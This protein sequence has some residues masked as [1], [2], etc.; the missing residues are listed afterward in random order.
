[1]LNERIEADKVR[2]LGGLSFSRDGNYL[3]FVKSEKFGFLQTLYRMSVLGGVSTQ[4]ISDVY[5]YALSPDG[6]QLAFVRNSQSAD[7]S[8]L[9]IANA[10]GT[11]AYR[12]ATRKFTDPFVSLG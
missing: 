9:M 12:L 3:Y 8:A 10:D 11:G 6:A 5:N 4:V 1:M 2:H 7:A